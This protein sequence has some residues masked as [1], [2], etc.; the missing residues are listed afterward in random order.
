MID[1]QNVF[2]NALWITALALTLSILSWSLWQAQEAG[3]PM[4]KALSGRFQRR[5]LDFSGV[6]F[7]AGLAGTTVELWQRLLWV[8]L[9][10]AFGVVLIFEK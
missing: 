1:W 5:A 10:L 7:C 2:F 9:A 4:S 6:L 3:L 8:V